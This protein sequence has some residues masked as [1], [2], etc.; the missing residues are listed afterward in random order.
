MKTVLP[1]EAHAKITCRLVPDQQPA[2]IAQLV[3]AQIERLT[4]P[5]VTVK[6][7]I[8]ANA[9]LPYSSSPDFAGNRAA[10]VVLEELY[11]KEPYYT[12]SGGSV[13]LLTMFYTELGAHTVNFGF[14][15]PDE[16]IHS[17]NEF[18]RLSSFRKAQQGYCLL[19]LELAGTQVK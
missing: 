10:H 16:N 4:P 6:V 15:L 3:K 13:P 18:W 11:G 2:H 14:G 7:T 9:A 1:S 8:F 12:R 19:L 17:P 5:G